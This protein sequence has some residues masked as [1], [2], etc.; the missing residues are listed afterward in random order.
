[1][2]EETTVLGE[3]RVREGDEVRGGV[4]IAGK[5]WSE[6]GGERAGEGDGVREGGD[7]AG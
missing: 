3:G 7:I 4:E 2:R 6:G 5:R 1:M